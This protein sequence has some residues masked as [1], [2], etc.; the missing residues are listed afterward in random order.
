MVIKDEDKKTKAFVEVRKF[1]KNNRAE[2]VDEEEL[3]EK[4]KDRVQWRPPGHLV[5]QNGKWRFCH[6][7]RAAID[8]ICLNEEL[9]GALNLLTPSSTQ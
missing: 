2:I 1:L 5:Y 8:G 6:D 3:R 4:P 7:G 9:I